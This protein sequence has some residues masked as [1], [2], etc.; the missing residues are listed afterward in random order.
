MGNMWQWGSLYL[1]ESGLVLA[2]LFVAFTFPRAGSHFFER[3]ERGL[4]RLARK[5]GLAVVL[6]GLAA[7]AARAALLPILP[8]PKP[9]VHDE[10]SYLLAAD[11]FAHGRLSNPTHPMWM[12]FES[13]HIIQKPTY[14]SMY[15]PAQGMFMAAGQVLLGHPFWGVWLSVGVMCA[16]ICWMLQGWLPPLWA[17]L[18]GLLAVIR[19]GT[20]SYWANSYWGGA[21]AAIGGALLLGAL[22]RIQR[23]QRARD[24]VVM[25]LGVTLLANSRPYEG[26]F[27]SLPVGLALVVWM[28]GKKAPPW[29]RSMRQVVLPLGLL[30]TLT[31]AAMLYYFW[32][33]T[34]SPFRT[35]FLVNIQTYNP[36]P[37]FAWQAVKPAPEYHHVVMKNFYTGWW[38]GQYEFARRHPVFLELIKSGTLWLFYFGPVLTLPI[39]MLVV[40]LPYGMS[41]GDIGRKV[42][43][44]L[45]V[46]YVASI[47]WLLPVYFNPHYAA[48]LTAAIY[49]LVLLAMQ[50][51]RRWQ[52]RREPTGL[53][54][55][56]A[57]PLICVVLLLLR[58]SAPLLH[59][60][61]PGPLPYSWCSQEFQMLDRAQILA[62][63]KGYSGSHLVIVRYKPDHGFV[64]EWVYNEADIDAARVV[65][66][67]EMSPVENEELLK[68]YESRHVWLL[69]PD[70]TPPRLSPY[71]GDQA[72]AADLITIENHGCSLSAATGRNRCPRQ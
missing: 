31:A 5:R 3:F 29:R 42:R 66:A 47:G 57:V 69:E 58:A 49:A 36:V 33:T 32:C 13:F 20:F 67:R 21:V 64:R 53:A 18:G 28:L 1:I 40:V 39:L 26:L 24:A 60:P 34:G 62:R 38:L 15:Y 61:R 17:L 52:W 46:C 48:P 8:V 12:H 9:T 45:L 43:L 4:A 55:V 59:V 50:R 51:V 72:V 68:Y 22:P 16:A 7:L 70:E 71:L 56:R 11:T 19:L 30:L 54:I 27:F 2:A 35:P 37:Y 65:W 14:V 44:L 63:L 23:S 6:V 25:G 41:Y 10:F